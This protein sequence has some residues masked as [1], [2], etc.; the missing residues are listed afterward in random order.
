MGVETSDAVVVT[1]GAGGPANGVEISE[2]AASTGEK[3]GESIAG[4]VSLS[5]AD[6][7][8]DELD[9]PT[10]ASFDGDAEL[11]ST[12]FSGEAFF[13]TRLGLGSEEEPNWTSPAVTTPGC[14]D[15]VLALADDV[16]ED[17]ES[18]TELEAA[19]LLL[20]VF[21]AFLLGAA[22]EAEALSAA[23]AA[24]AAFLSSLFRF[25]SALAAASAAALSS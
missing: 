2:V 22:V 15:E 13:L 5:C 23:A 7:A 18:V 19:F 24:S 1:G 11:D 9:G 4:V 10:S 14:C 25:L 6:E 21:S 8:E 20:E 16:D 17:A 3:W 12:Y